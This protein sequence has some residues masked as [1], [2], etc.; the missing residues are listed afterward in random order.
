MCSINAWQEFDELLKK[1]RKRRD[2]VL[3]LN[4]NKKSFA[5][6][7]EKQNK[8]VLIE[9][10]YTSLFDVY[11]KAL[12]QAQ[13]GKGKKRHANELDF[14]DQP[15]LMISRSLNSVNG[16]LFQAM[17]KITEIQNI[18]DTKAK[19][20]ELLGAMNYIAAAVIYLEDKK[21]I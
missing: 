4:D 14:K 10:E 6:V 2:S 12:E 1:L 15:I 19:V 8:G 3:E 20:N 9:K 16:V 5:E 18:P 13:H 7:P 17:K 21:E 11:L